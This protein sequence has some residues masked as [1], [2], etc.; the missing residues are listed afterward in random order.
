MTTGSVFRLTVAALAPLLACG[1][2]FGQTF[3]VL[4]ISVTGP[5]EK[6]INIVFLGDGYT[7]GEMAK[8]ATD[9]D[10]ALLGLFAAT[11]YDKYRNYFNVYAVEVPSNESGCDHPATASDE[12]GG[13]GVLNKDTYF[14]S[15]FDV[16]GIHRLLVPDYAPALD[17]LQNHFPAWD[18][19]FVV[20]NQPWYGGSGGT[21]ATFSTE[22]SSSEIAIHEL[23]HSFAS[24]ADEY[25]TGGGG[26]YEAPN[27]TSETDRD[28]I[29][30]N[31]WIDPSTP[32]PTPE[33]GAYGSVVGLFEGAVYNPVGWYRPK[34]NCKMRTLG[35]FFCAVC[36]EQSVL[37]MYG[38]LRPI[39]AAWPA[40]PGY[41]LHQD[42]VVN[43]WI[44]SPKPIPNTMARVWYVDGQIQAS[45]VDTLPIDGSAFD[46]GSHVIQVVVT[47]STSLV[48]SDSLEWLH[49]SLTWTLEVQPI[50]YV[51]GDADANGQVTS[52]DIIL[53]VNHVF[54]SGPPPYPWQAAGDLNC[55]GVITS[56][57]I[58][59][60][61]NYVFKGA[62]APV[63]P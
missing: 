27:A 12:P 57:D 50:P 4:E 13:F 9:I 36:A 40:T 38:L 42:T 32:I 22:S 56:G 5:S 31:V 51:L 45:G 60:H 55:N 20:V 11:P 58:V 33:T 23:G 2:L 28:S 49:D 19:A 17:V 25:E 44:Q 18:I 7:A 34:L 37:S 16:G 6:R 35:A 26:G 62:A 63:C 54:K 8:Y 39:E 59:I 3:P 24:L 43:F 61:V 10:H 15:S 48:R 14:N 30:W 21:F 1:T 52:A 29:R 53:L 46:T 47:D 41:T